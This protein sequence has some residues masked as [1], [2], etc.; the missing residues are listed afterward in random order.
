MAWTVVFDDVFDREFETLADGVQDALLASAKLLAEYGPRLGRPHVDTLAG[1]TYANMK[2]LRFEADGGVWRI[3]FAF[4][5]RR[6]AILLVAGDKA[7]VG[8]RRFYRAL[9]AKADRRYAAHLARLA[10]T[11]RG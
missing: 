2:E 11:G 7:G 5:P 3:A 8:G 6:H 10:G 4:D 9:I 1:S